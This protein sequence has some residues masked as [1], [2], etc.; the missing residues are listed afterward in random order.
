MTTLQNPFDCRGPLQTLWSSGRQQQHNAR[1]QNRGIEALL[2]LGRNVILADL[3]KEPG[4]GL[5]TVLSTFE[6]MQ[7]S[8]S[9]TK[10]NVYAYNDSE[11]QFEVTPGLLREEVQITQLNTGI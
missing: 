9:R 1:V 2:K 4:K 11:K 3:G 10:K 8:E 7:A 5:A 6:S